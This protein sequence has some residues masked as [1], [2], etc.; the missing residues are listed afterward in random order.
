MTKCVCGSELS[1]VQSDYWTYSKGVRVKV[2]NV[3]A[4]ECQ[5]GDFGLTSEGKSFLS[6]ELNKHKE[7]VLEFKLV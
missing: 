2:E 3:E 1:I 5:C 7:S 6:R 4:Y